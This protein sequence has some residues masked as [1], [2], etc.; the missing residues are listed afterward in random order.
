MISESELWTEMKI[1]KKNLYLSNN[2]RPHK[3]DTF[4]SFEQSTISR[5]KM[6]TTKSNVRLSKIITNFFSQDILQQERCIQCVLCNSNELRKEN[7]R[8][9]FEESLGKFAE[10]LKI[11][12]HISN[13]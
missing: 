5:E 2:M 10:I 4:L 1:Y 12:E 6:D 7:L 3:N 8:R 9:L 11:I 13:L